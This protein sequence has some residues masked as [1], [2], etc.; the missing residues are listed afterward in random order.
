MSRECRKCGNI[1]PFT[2]KIDGK[3]RNLK[4]RK[5]CLECSPFGSRNT[6]PDDPSRP[7][8]RPVKDGKRSTFSTWSPEAQER[9]RAMQYYYRWKRMKKCIESKGGKCEKCGYDKCSRSL[10]FHHTY[11]S[12]KRYEI[13]ARNIM[14]HSWEDIQKELSTC[15]L[16][17]LNCH[18]EIHAKEQISK[19]APF[20]KEKYGVEV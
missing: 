2:K 7:S 8:L 12:V 1:I 9:N 6:K 13:S 16:L 17:C 5:F 3:L 11:P 10:C 18:N 4:N 14:S 15:Q 19:Y 20:I